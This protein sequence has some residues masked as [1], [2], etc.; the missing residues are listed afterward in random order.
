M[1]F[2]LGGQLEFFIKFPTAK[3]RVNLHQRVLTPVGLTSIEQTKT[4]FYV[5][6]CLLNFNRGV[7]GLPRETHG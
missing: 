4:S 1:D 2:T 5:Q 7:L 6:L 3:H